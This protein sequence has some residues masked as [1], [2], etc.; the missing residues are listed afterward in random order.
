[1]PKPG[2]L[3]VVAKSYPGT[4]PET[5]ASGMI[6]HAP[7]PVINGPLIKTKRLPVEPISEFAPTKPMVLATPRDRPVEVIV[8]D[9]PLLVFSLMLINDPPVLAPRVIVPTSS[10]L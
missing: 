7:V 8:A 5:V 2:M 10:Q 4:G 9:P 6:P 3:T 1:M